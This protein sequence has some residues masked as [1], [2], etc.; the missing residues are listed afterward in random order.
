[1][2]SA[3]STPTT[4]YS[5]SD[6][7]P[8]PLPLSADAARTLTP[9]NS[10]ALAVTTPA[11][12]RLCPAA[13]SACCRSAELHTFAGQLIATKTSSPDRSAVD[14]VTSAML[15]LRGPGRHSTFAIVCVKSPGRLESDSTSR[16]STSVV[17]RSYAGCTGAV[18]QLVSHCAVGSSSLLPGVTGATPLDQC[19][20]SWFACCCPASVTFSMTCRDMVSKLGTSTYVAAPATR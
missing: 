2:T 6:P 4:T 10:Y 13:I 5:V 19:A 1:M 16:T 17:T 7:F 20:F 18:A 12:R 8:S 14:P 15:T 11:I 3:T 9:S